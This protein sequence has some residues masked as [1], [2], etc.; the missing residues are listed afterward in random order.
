MHS[1]FAF[2]L[3]ALIALLFTACQSTTPSDPS[4]PTNPDTIPPTLTSS[5]PANKTTDVPLNA[6][7]S[8]TFSEPINMGKF[9]AVSTPAADL[10][11][12]TWNAARTILQLQ[13][14]GD[15]QPETTYTVSF[16]AQDDAGN[17]LGARDTLIFRTAKLPDT[18]PPTV[19]SSDPI[20]GAKDVGLS[21]TLMTVRFS[22]V[23][24]TAS[25]G[26]DVRVRCRYLI[27]NCTVLNPTVTKSAES[28]TVSLSNA[29][30][31]EATYT[32]IVTGTDLAG[33]ALPSTTL[34]FTTLKDSTPPTVLGVL[35][36]NGSSG[37]APDAVMTVAFSE[38]MSEAS[39]TEGISVTAGDEFPAPVSVTIT[40]KPGTDA[41]TIQ[42]V[43]GFSYGDTIRLTVGPKALDVSG[44]AVAQPIV[45]TFSVLN[46]ITLT[47]EAT[48]SA[49]GQIRES[50]N[51]ISGACNKLVSVNAN[52]FW[53]GQQ[54]G[55]TERINY[56]SFLSFDLSSL[57]AYS[58]SKFVGAQLSIGGHVSGHVGNPFAVQGAL[59]IERIQYEDLNTATYDSAVRGCGSAAVCTTRFNSAPERDNP[60]DVLNNVTQDWADGTLRSQLRLRFENTAQSGTSY[61]R[62]YSANH[63]N[64]LF[65][66]TL[67]ITFE[68]P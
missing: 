23:M 1:R 25:L 27:P 45:S 10:G 48:P 43:G 54:D 7:L 41:Y 35:P 46:R 65:R 19:T 11:V 50:C 55:G 44:N 20:N 13:P 64:N 14:R 9:K 58:I 15:L 33:N 36:A 22:E 18:T 16:T 32:V 63:P 56:R 5:Q 38:P 61:L 6:R 57:Q 3:P 4:P 8:F 29:S 30:L 47:L 2:F 53:I 68:T 26:V 37:I 67:S 51:V 34:E 31:T 62:Y 39:L 17:A 24:N 59:L 42:P 52:E 66:P 12:G 40:R 21:D 60:V 49:D 28:I